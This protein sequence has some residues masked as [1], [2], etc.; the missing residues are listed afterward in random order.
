MVPLK[1]RDKSMELQAEMR[2]PL[3]AVELPVPA[4][5]VMLASGRLFCLASERG[6]D[7]LTVRSPSGRVELR[8]QFTDRGPVLSFEAADLHLSGTRALR[9]DADIIE[10]SAGELRTAVSG[11]VEEH[12]GGD[13]HT[14]IGGADRLE[15]ALLEVQA[16]EEAVHIRAAGRIALDGEHIGL[17]DDLCPAPFPWS[18]PAEQQGVPA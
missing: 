1:D 3:D 10:V 12:I 8:V 11:G 16:N 7:A 5:N 18:I 9:L 2:S 14:H 15:A 13:R 17:N 4:A 6:G